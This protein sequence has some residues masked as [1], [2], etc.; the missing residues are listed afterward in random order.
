MPA[1]SDFFNDIDL[2]NYNPLGV[3]ICMTLAV[4]GARGDFV[5]G[6]LGS[7]PGFLTNSWNIDAETGQSFTNY[8]FFKSLSDDPLSFL[9]IINM[10]NQSGLRLDSNGMF[11]TCINHKSTIVKYFTENT[12]DQIFFVIIDTNFSDKP[13][14]IWER[15]IKTFLTDMRMPDLITKT[16]TVPCY[17][18]DE[19]L[20]RERREISDRERIKRFFKQIKS[21]WYEDHMSW[22][23]TPTVPDGF[24]SVTLK[25][26]DLFVPGGSRHLSDRMNLFCTDR[27]HDLW[28][29]NLRS[30]DS[31]LEIV[32]FGHVINFHRVM[33]YVKLN[34]SQRSGIV[35]EDIFPPAE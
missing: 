33:A 32:R 30:A 31:P 20:L 16:K 28:D 5:S 2:Q 14:I 9:G 18:I 35:L 34:Q 4:P 7:L 17:G 19:N 21:Y 10:L 1:N 29:Q 22:D 25:Y 6:W 12:K 13:K 15:M 23:L 11:I 8:R 26:S 24:S 3:R 27:H